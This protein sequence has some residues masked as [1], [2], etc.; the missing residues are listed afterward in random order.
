MHAA[1]GG[2]GGGGGGSLVGGGWRCCEIG[3]K[4]FMRFEHGRELICA[5]AHEEK[6]KEH[7]VS[8]WLE[9]VWLS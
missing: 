5:R 3:W 1:R 9:H 7:K 8:S 2:G 6:R 4:G